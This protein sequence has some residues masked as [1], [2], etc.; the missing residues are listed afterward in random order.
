MKSVEETPR[1]LDDPSES[2]GDMKLGLE[3]LSSDLPSAEAMARMAAKFGITPSGV[4][5]KTPTV[6]P[7]L[8][9]KLVA[10]IGISAAVLW[11]VTRETT[12]HSESALEPAPSVP[13][14]EATGEPSVAVA[15]EAASP[16]GVPVARASRGDGERPSTVEKS[17]EALPSAASPPLEHSEPRP[18]AGVEP[19]GAPP[20][21]LERSAPSPSGVRSP[22][23]ST[24]RASEPSRAPVVP[25][26]APQSEPS[27][28]RDARLALNGDPGR[29]LALTEKHR[30]DFPAGRLVQ[31]REVIAITALARL[32]RLSEA[33]SR[34]E[35]FRGAYPS[36]PY[37]D[38]VD[39]VVPP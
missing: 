18:A 36:S 33:R 14:L 32:G 13:S 2:L 35:R 8:L 20:S 26:A 29:A 34:A 6:S 21:P 28:L 3:R 16:R 12:R 31:E 17:V 10:G 30:S 1:L 5:V 9:A 27:L 24:D 37:V 11:G 38:R 25:V 22:E 39:R 15:R 4:P 19:R 23:R 7:K